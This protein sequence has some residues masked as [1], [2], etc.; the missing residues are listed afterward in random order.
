MIPPR[1]VVR[2]HPVVLLA[3]VL[4][5]G[6][7]APADGAVIFNGSGTSAAGNP[8]AFR[9]TLSI[10]GTQ[11]S[12]RLDNVS[13]V[14]T[15]GSADVLSSFYFDV[16]KSG[17]IRPTLTFLS[18][19]GQVY[20][21]LSGTADKPVVYQPTAAPSITPG[22]GPSN[23]RAVNPQDKT[24]QLRAMNPSL[25]PLEGFG[26]GTVRNQNLAPN[27]FDPAIVGPSGPSQIAFSIYTG[28]DINPNPADYLDKQFLVRDTA[29]FTFGL[30]RQ[31]STFTD[32]DIGPDALFGLGV[33]PD[34]VI[35]L[36]EP[37]GLALAAGGCVV[38]GVLRLAR[39][40]HRRPRG[41]V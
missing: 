26:I 37:G 39:R 5:G 10:T 31:G 20:Q 38:A 19:T 13:P 17:S 2:L 16:V 33:G 11:L 40:R 41:R 8:V 29:T 3:C 21:V 34:S 7:A 25:P 30:F 32:A 6:A 28:A 18:G 1:T 27:G 35:E 24:W 4:A 22:F 36:P 14:P 12:V 15:I 23:L 9:A